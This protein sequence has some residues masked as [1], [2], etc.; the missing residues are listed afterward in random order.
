MDGDPEEWGIPESERLRASLPTPAQPAVHVASVSS[1]AHRGIPQGKVLGL[2][3]AGSKGLPDFPHP[4]SGCEAGNRGF[5]E[6]LSFLEA[7][8]S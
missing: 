4:G 2:G 7:Y 6:L 1:C 8:E 3:G 5:L